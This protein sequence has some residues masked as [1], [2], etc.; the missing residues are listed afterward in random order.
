MSTAVRI[1]A[2]LFAAATV[3]GP[4]AKLAKK[5]ITPLTSRPQ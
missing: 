2:A 5:R 1:L 4:M 3:I